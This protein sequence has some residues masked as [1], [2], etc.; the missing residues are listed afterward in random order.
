MSDVVEENRT[1][2]YFVLFSGFSMLLINSNDV[3][4]YI[5]YSRN[6]GGHDGGHDVCDDGD[7]HDGGHS[8][9]GLFFSFYIYDRNN[10]IFFLKHHMDRNG[11][12]R[13]IYL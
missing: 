3:F 1:T 9:D 5:Y 11:A 10:H 12:Y 7:G 2:N 8:S 6:D 13:H 4:S